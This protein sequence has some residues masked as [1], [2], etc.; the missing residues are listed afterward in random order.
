MTVCQNMD[1]MDDIAFTMENQWNENYIKNMYGHLETIMDTQSSSIFLKL[2][3]DEVICKTFSMVHLIQQMI[4]C[5]FVTTDINEY[6]MD[7]E[8][9]LTFLLFHYVNHL[10]TE[11]KNLFTTIL[12][13][14]EEYDDQYIVLQNK[15][16]DCIKLCN[17]ICLNKVQTYLNQNS[18]KIKEK[19]K[20]ASQKTQDRIKNDFLQ[21]S[22]LQKS[23]NDTLY[24]QKK[25]FSKQTFNNEYMAF[26]N[27][28]HMKFSY[29]TL[30]L[31]IAYLAEYQLNQIY[32]ILIGQSDDPDY[33]DIFDMN[34]WK[35]Y[36]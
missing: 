22:L 24:I 10:F 20:Y 33:R 2:D 3:S 18:E 11:L 34:N 25:L 29:Y 16:E 7:I 15:L 23:D 30:C 6:A 12:S 27:I 5:N 19:L 9:M 35:I 28:V 31:L 13:R 36:Y 32:T 21:F 8:P 17:S 1:I 14:V 4:R 26:I